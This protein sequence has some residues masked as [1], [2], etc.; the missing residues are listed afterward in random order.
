M[1]TPNE[2]IFE[3]PMLVAMHPYILEITLLFLNSLGVGK[4]NVC[5]LVE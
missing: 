5:E 2:A 1:M 4:Y 3:V